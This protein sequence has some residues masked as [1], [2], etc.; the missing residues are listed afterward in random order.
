MKIQESFQSPH[1]HSNEIPVEFLIL[2]YTGCDLQKTLDIFMNPTSKV[3]SHFVLDQNG[4]CYDLGGFL[5]GPIRQGSHAGKSS[6]NLKNRRFESFNEFSIGIEIV[7]LNGNL[8]PFTEA[9]Y[10]SLQKL[11]QELQKRFPQLK[12]A[13]RI[14][15]HEHIASSRGKSDPGLKF[16]WSRYLHSIGLKPLAC[17]DFHVCE[18]MDLEW[19]QK[20][21]DATPVSKQDREFWP[22]LNLQ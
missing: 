13:E 5:H 3:C 10:E 20:E 14:L 9:Q 4:T 7:N 15:G 17:H 11:T 6:F 18:K 22:A 2:H 21:I 1:F 12:H 19:L 8:F 16:D